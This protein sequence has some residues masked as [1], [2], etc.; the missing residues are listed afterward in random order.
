M[1]LPQAKMGGTGSHTSAQ[2]SRQT[3]VD[4]SA[5]GRLQAGAR[6]ELSWAE[7]WSR[8]KCASQG[9]LPG[10]RGLTQWP[11]GFPQ[12]GG[13]PS[14]LPTPFWLPGMCPSYSTLF[15]RP[16]RDR[17]RASS[18]AASSPSRFQD[19]LQGRGPRSVAGEQ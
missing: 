7:V 11:L 4:S 12:E 18:A 15:S 6:G 8:P 16:I 19:S 3:A 14:A 13:P 9:G 5:A 10:G 17:T 2:R 1:S